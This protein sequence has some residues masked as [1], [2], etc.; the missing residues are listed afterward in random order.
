MTSYTKRAVK[1]T[2]IVLVIT[3]MGAFVGYLVRLLFARNLTA[4]EFGLF[5]AVIGFLSFFTIFDNLG[6]TTSITKFIPEFKIKREGKLIKNSV[7]ITFFFTILFLGLV[8][9][10]LFTLSAYLAIHF[11][12]NT[13]V[14]LV[15]RL[16]L[17][18]FISMGCVYIIRACFLGLQKMAYYSSIELATISLIWIISF[19][20]FKYIQKTHIKLY[21]VPVIAYV[22]TPL[23]IIIIYFPLLWKTLSRFSR[24]KPSFDKKLAKRL[25]L[26]GL[27]VMLGAAGELVLGYTDTMM[28]TYFRSFDEVGWYNIALPTA[29][30]LA[31]FAIPLSAVLFPMASELWTKNYKSH[32]K[33]GIEL[34]YKY[35]LMITMPFALIL[36]LFPTT[37]I[38]LLFGNKFI[39]ASDALRILSLGAIFLVIFRINGSIITGIGKPKINAKIIYT[40]AIFNLIFNFILIPKYGITGAA[41]TTAIGFFLM[42]VLGTIYL[43]NIIQLELPV[44]IWVKNV[45]IALVFVFITSYLK[46]RLVIGNAWLEMAIII[47]IAGIVYI[48]LLFL[49]KLVKIKEIKEITARLRA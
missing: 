45:I 9:I 7:I 39:P 35:C 12:H 6:L 46:N 37:L 10:I 41:I 43:K 3:M 2:M 40:G 5:Y 11:F 44:K 17:V 15:L 48:M 20:L 8:S 14:V 24:I 22:L 4:E 36:M 31:Y 28:L 18:W 30:L 33:E 38:N 26:F 42:A 47:S 23:I 1:G 49:L 27:P 32:L 19:V 34:L 16:L 29:R 13:H 25:I 21:Y